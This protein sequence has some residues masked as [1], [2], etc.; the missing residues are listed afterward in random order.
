MK[1]LRMDWNIRGATSWSRRVGAAF[2]ADFIVEFRLGSFPTVNSL[3]EKGE[4]AH[5]FNTYVKHLKARYAKCRNTGEN[6]N[7]YFRS[8]RRRKQVFICANSFNFCASLFSCSFWTDAS[9][10]SNDTT[11]LHLRTRLLNCWESTACLA[12]RVKERS[13]AKVD[14]SVSNYCLGV[15]GWRLSGCIASIGCP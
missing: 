4:I 15:T 9:Q 13:E 5:T 8:R 10:Q 1:C 12:K 6:R 11:C 14:S 2:E 3:P 7:A